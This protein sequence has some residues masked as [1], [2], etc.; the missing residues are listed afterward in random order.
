MEVSVFPVLSS[1]VTRTSLVSETIGGPPTHF[2]SIAPVC[3]GICLPW[4]VVV[5]ADE[6]EPGTCKNYEIMRC[7]PHKLIEGCLAAGHSMN[8]NATNIDIRGEFSQEAPHV[9]PAIEQLES[10]QRRIIWKERLRI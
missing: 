3:S 10:L 5:N 1:G 4:Y 8:F 9:Q 6:A 7:N 2:T